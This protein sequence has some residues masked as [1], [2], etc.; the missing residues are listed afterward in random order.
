MPCYAGIGSRSTPLD[1]LSYMTA[2]GYYM[3]SKGWILR[4]G[5]ALGADSAF[6]QGCNKWYYEN[7]KNGWPIPKEIFKAWD[8]KRDDDSLIALNMAS[9][10]HPN[11]PACTEHVRKLHARNIFQ[12]HGRNFQEPVK[13]VI[14]WTPRGEDVG[15]TRT[16]IVAARKY[17]IKIYNLANDATLDYIMN[18]FHINVR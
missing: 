9:T 6:E 4:S 17:G 13:S 2:I 7:A 11:W 5:G 14:C 8:I 16:A 12:I 18:R 3:A 15:G 1:I 10:I